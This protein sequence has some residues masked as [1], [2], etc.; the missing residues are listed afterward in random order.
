MTCLKAKQESSKFYFS[1][2]LLD[3]CGSRMSN[4][5]PSIPSSC[6]IYHKEETSYIAF[7]S[8]SLTNHHEFV[9]FD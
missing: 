2:V 1:K 4:A 5:Y 6:K 7:T 8:A 9:H 3:S